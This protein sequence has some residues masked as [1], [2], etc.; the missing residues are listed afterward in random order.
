MAEAPRNVGA[1]IKTLDRDELI[2]I[3]EE[4]GISAK[5]TV[6]PST[7]AEYLPEEIIMYRGMGTLT[8]IEPKNMS[9]DELH[10]SITR[11]VKENSWA[12]GLLEIHFKDTSSIPHGPKYWLTNLF[13]PMYSDMTPEGLQAFS[14]HEAYAGVFTYRPINTL[15]RENNGDMRAFA[16][17]LDDMLAKDGVSRDLES[18]FSMAS[19]PQ[20]TREEIARARRDLFAKLRV[21][22]EAGQDRE[23]WHKSFGYAALIGMGEGGN[24]AGSEWLSS[25]L[26]LGQWYAKGIQGMTTREKMPENLY[27]Y[28][29]STHEF[30]GANSVDDIINKVG[31]VFREPGV[32][33]LEMSPTYFTQITE[34][35][36]TVRYRIYLPEGT[37]FGV[38]NPEENEVMLPPG[39]RYAVLKALLSDQKNERGGR[40]WEVD[41]LALPPE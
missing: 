21:D 13:R 41:L 28:R 10:S 11:F 32:T 7:V 16:A 14:A 36:G 12:M 18:F 17:D 34:W 37:L 24:L 20:T 31:S 33:S 23:N 6:I 1:L 30:M 8:H 35:Y 19:N 22:P 4:L 38:G 15:L 39:T 2:E 40:L 5:R 27:G 25:G 9:L 3:A 26:S 29:V